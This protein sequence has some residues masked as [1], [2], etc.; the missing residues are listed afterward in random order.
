MK[1]YLR[2]LLPNLITFS[3]L[4]C[5]FS[6]VVLAMHE[7][8]TASGVCILTGYLLDALDGEVARRTGSASAFGLELDSLVDLVTF[9]V[10][11]S[12]L[13]Y[14]YLQQLDFSPVVVWG[15]CAAYMIGG[16]F[17]LARFN[18]LPPKRSGSESVGLTIS[19]SGATL[20]LS[21]LSNCRYDH[22]LIPA[23]IFPVLVV[24]LT[25]L[26]MSR[27]RYPALA[28][29]FKHRWLSM[30]GL[31]SATVLA[32]WLSPQLVWFGLTGGYVSFGLARAIYAMFH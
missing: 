15:A 7:E 31:G 14:Q 5:A 16:A 1:D 27:I 11:P 23:A 18:L 30:T 19:T 21:V 4:V 29:V 8:L 26:M 3:A 22:Q 17:R 28:S 12:A 24:V 6:A 2:G 9:G 25:L 13:V 32:I 10:A 20:A